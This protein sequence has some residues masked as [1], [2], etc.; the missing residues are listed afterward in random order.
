MIDSSQVFPLLVSACP[1]F[2]EV[3]ASSAEQYGAELAYVHAGAFAQHLL[4]LHE[5]GRI[6][7]LQAAGKAIESLLS[8]GNA[9]VTKLAIVGVLEGI[10]NSWSS[11]GTDPEFF[12]R[13]LGPIGA[14]SWVE[15]NVGWGGAA[16]PVV[17][18]DGPASGGSAA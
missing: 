4:T 18:A 9:A 14:R 15:L 11:S 13:Y 2:A 6:E 5:D 12:V 16:Q 3:Y 17:Q 7:A 1:S 10:Q 8:E